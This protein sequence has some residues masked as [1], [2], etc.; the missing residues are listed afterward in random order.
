MNALEVRM[1]D[2]GARRTRY[3]RPAL[4]Q[5]PALVPV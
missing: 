4:G 5:N 3:L 1:R 2:F